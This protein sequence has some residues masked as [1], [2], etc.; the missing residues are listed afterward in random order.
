MALS[1]R[2]HPWRLVGLLLV[3][4]GLVGLGIG[5]VLYLRR[6]P[7]LP[8]ADNP[9]YHE[10][11]RAF[12]V[13]VAALDTEQTDVANNKL[14]LAIDTIPQEPAAWA[15]RGL[16]RL[17]NNQLDE[18]AQ[19]LQK[20]HELAPESSAI[21]ALLGL[22]AEKQGRF[23]EAVA[24]F[25]RALELDPQDVVTRFALATALAREGGPD[26]DAEY[27]KQLEEILKVQPNNLFVLKERAGAALRRGDAAAFRDTLERFQ[28]LYGSWA[29]DA[30]S[31]LTALLK[32]AQGPLRGSVAAELAQFNNLLIAQR[33]FSRSRDAVD[34]RPDVV[35]QPIERFLRLP[36]PRPSPAPPDLDLTFT[37]RPVP[38]VAR[39]FAPVRWDI[40]QPVWLAGRGEPAILVANATQVLRYDTAGPNLH[41]PGGV[42]P[43]PPTAAGILAFDWN[44]D[45]RTDL[46]LAGAGGLGFYQQ[47]EDG[48]FTDVTKKVGLDAGV[49]GA[50]YYGAWAADIDMDGDLD[51]ILA[52]RGAPPLVLRNNRDGTFTVVRPFAGVDNV[53]AFAW[54]DLDN[55]GAPDAVFVNTQGHLQVFANERSGQF[56]PRTAPRVGG[57]LLALAVADVND[58]G[59]LDLVILRGDGAVIRV[60]DKDKGQSWDIAEIA[61]WP[62]IAD[63]LPP[64]SV[65]LLVA[66]L[67]NNGALD[68][69][70]AG[71]KG[72]RVWLSAGPDKFQMLPAAFTEPVFAAVDLTGKGR[73]DLLGLSETGQPVQLVNRGAKNYHW[74][75]VW[76]RGSKEAQ[77]DNRIN[78]FGIGGEIEARSGTLV[79]KQL[80]ATPLVHFG[81]GDQDQID[82]LRIQ[83]P[84]GY[85]QVEF[86]TRADTMVV[87]E[88]RLKGSC[89]FLFAYDGTGVQFVTDFMWSTPLGMYINAQDKGGFLQTT[90]WVK[91]RGDQLAPK[92]GV[93]DLRVTANLWETHYYDY[94]A[95]LV[96]DHPAGT[97]M[98]VDE[99]FF[100]TPTEPQVFLTAPPVPVAHAWDDHGQD[101]TDV[102]RAI[103]GRY[104]D[105]CSR[106]QFQ[107]VTRD[108]WVEV[109]LGDEA[110]TGEPLWLVAHGWVHPTDSSINFALEQGKH[111]P[112]RGLVLE[113]PDGK[114]GWTVGRPALGFPA[115]KHKTIMIRL[116]GINGS[117]VSRR[118]RLRTNMEI[119]WDAL[120]YA[121]GLDAG[122]CRQ[123][124][125]NPESAELRYYGFSQM[126]Q[127]NPSS[128]ELPHYDK[129]MGRSQHWRDLLGYYTR[130][131]DVRELLATVDDRY[132]IMNGGDEI[133]LQ[134]RVTEGPPS[135]WKRDFV[136]ACD[137]WAKD[138]DLNTRF[139][140]TV[141][142]LPAH[143]IKTY[144]RPPGPLEDDPVYRRF[145]NDWK[146]YHTRHVT[147][148][149]YDRGLRSFKVVKP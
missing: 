144:V 114:G 120:L 48:S 106:G 103:D 4:G 137:G 117:G 79:Q 123:Q 74:Q 65:H 77:G 72:G 148:S 31:R 76:P 83:W 149:E 20:S 8:D 42:R 87:A 109:D 23:P 86:E 121:R 129:L 67:D 90:D 51:V 14:S 132:V 91:I 80:I 73:L 128:P 146:K 82:V 3:L 58:D 97:E 30:R 29:A 92:N 7:Q 38:N 53:C 138:G 2:L 47:A 70:A 19:D 135:G 130:Y 10:Y 21:E 37:A 24:H 59:V 15:D 69:V 56:R 93:Y 75:V 102:V 46:L 119:Y 98:F 5:G 111:E 43:V 95:L 143:D 17:R 1:F 54:A 104:L 50:N 101:V 118:F 61:R 63:D 107:G 141:L 55:D 100:L 36:P 62:D 39:N 41:F 116:D 125:L 52:P 12:Q 26:S 66:D 68:L 6:A 122:L 145:P 133:K 40:A 45:F 35:G 27:Q 131:G 142:P 11:L 18:A 49:L 78:S 105:T 44:N 60:S 94:M 33:G 71:P 85:P 115:G 9:R 16:L 113:V 99:R 88:Q 81:L 112:P 96:V 25:R 57:P 134:F 34:P 126:T 147:P 84:N 108:H 136:W 139:S 89:P 64:G 22:L 28:K 140:K 13:G 110:P 32:S 127:A 124:W